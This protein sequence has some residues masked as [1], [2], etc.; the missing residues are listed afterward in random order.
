MPCYVGLLFFVLQVSLSSANN[1]YEVMG[2]QPMAYELV[3]PENEELRDT[4]PCCEPTCDN[5]CKNVKC[6]NAYVR[7]PTCV[8]KEGYVRHKGKCIPYHLCPAKPPTPPTCGENEELLPSPPSCEPT[9]TDDC[10]GRPAHS[11]YLDQPTCVCKKGYRRHKGKCVRVDQCPSCGPYATLTTSAP[12]CEPT[13]ENDCSNVLCLSPIQTD[14]PVCVCQDGYVKHNSTCIKRELCPQTVYL[15]PKQ[16]CRCGGKRK[17]KGRVPVP[18]KYIEVTTKSPPPTP[19]C[20]C[21]KQQVNDEQQSDCY[22]MSYQPMI[23]VSPVHTTTAAPQTYSPIQYGPPVTYTPPKN[24]PRQY[25]QPQA[26][27]EQ[28]TDPPTTYAPPP[29]MPPKQYYY[30][31]QSSYHPAPASPPYAYT[32]PPPVE[33]ST[34]S[35]PPPPPPKSSYV[36]PSYTVPPPCDGMMDQKVTLQ[37]PYYYQPTPPPK[38]YTYPPATAQPYLPYHP[39][40]SKPYYQQQPPSSY[41]D[42]PYYAIP[43]L[44]QCSCS[45]NAAN[46]GQQQSS[47]GRQPYNRPPISYNVATPSTTTVAPTTTACPPACPCNQFYNYHH[48]SVY[49]DQPYVN[50]PPPTTA[51][52]PIDISYIALPGPNCLNAVTS[53]PCPT[54]C[55]TQPPCFSAFSAAK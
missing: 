14:E 40:T 50:Q 43:A 2:E 19:P 5:D 21:Q 13:C 18:V 36:L 35:P 7:Q 17:P 52:L 32:P 31:P 39:T 41:Q 38:P 42:Q 12:C 51:P 23:Y 26:P 49:K 25:H 54:P 11:R 29:T 33:D 8:C 53:P 6:A 1:Y 24:V 28:R 48:P 16:Y 47:C 10:A 3:C 4:M 45:I 46:G 15:V 30:H 34:C 20:S 27:C 22:Q 9:C 55:P 37:P 44:K